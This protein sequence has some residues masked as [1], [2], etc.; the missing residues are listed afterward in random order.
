[1]CFFF[2]TEIFFV[3]VTWSSTNFVITDVIFYIQYFHL[4]FFFFHSM[5]K[6]SQFLIFLSILLYLYFLIQLVFSEPNLHAQIFI[7][8]QAYSWNHGASVTCVVN[9]GNLKFWLH[10]WHRKEKPLISRHKFLS[11]SVEIVVCI[12][13]RKCQVSY[14]SIHFIIFMFVKNP[15]LG[16]ITVIEQDILYFSYIFD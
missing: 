15:N 7:F 11:W 13:W 8:T 2:T 4:V 10:H 12:L 6:M 16:E 14:F 5:E 9:N 3:I 1:M